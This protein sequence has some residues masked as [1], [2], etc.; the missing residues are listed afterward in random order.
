MTEQNRQF[1]DLERQVPD[2]F[3]RDLR[4]LFEPTASVPPQVDRAILDQARRRLARP[5]RVILRIRWAAGV[6]AAALIALGMLLYYGPASSNHPSSIIH[7]PSAAA[8]RADLDGNG[9]VDILD[10]FRLAKDIES[11]APAQTQWDVNGDGRVDRDD[12]DAIA[13]AAVRLNKGA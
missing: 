4:G 1:D 2:R 3:R 7:H 9:R 10:A 8:G 11:R 12:V 5:R 6:A 13:F